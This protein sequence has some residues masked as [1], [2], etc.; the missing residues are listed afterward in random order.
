MYSNMSQYYASDPIGGERMVLSLPFMWL[1]HNRNIISEETHVL[2]A[3]CTLLFQY[4]H[5]F[6]KLLLPGV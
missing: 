6:G 1:Q 2:G 4:I 3:Q 5:V